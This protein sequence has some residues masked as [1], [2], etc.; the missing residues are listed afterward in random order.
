MPTIPYKN[1]EGKRVSGVTTIIGG[2]LGWN[3]QALMWWA[4]EM[5]L[6]GKNHRDEAKEAADAGTLCHALIEKDILKMMPP[7]HKLVDIEKGIKKLTID[8]TDEQLS[9][10]ETGFLNFLEWKRMVN[11]IPKFMPIATELTL[12]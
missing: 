4:N 8:L 2:N 11:F 1:K 6:Q 10:A 5:G 12:S 3:K 7:S 9:K